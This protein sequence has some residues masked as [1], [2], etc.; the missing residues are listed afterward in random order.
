MRDG[1]SVTATTVPKTVWA[2]GFVSMLMDL[3][4]E[5]VHSLLPLF[6][7]ST[8]GVGALL[9]GLIEGI[10][11][12]TASITKLFSGA[13]SDR[14]GRRKGLVLFGY[15]LSALTKPVFALAPSV[16]WVVTA[17]FADRLGKGIRG[18]PRDALVADVTP[19]PLLGAAFG[20]RQSFDTVG[21]LAGPL[22]AM[23]LMGLTHNAFRLT[24]WAA[25]IPAAAAVLLIVFGVQEPE[26]HRASG[27]PG[28][29]FIQS[30][31]A[32]MG[33]AFWGA[34]AIGTLMT[35]ARFSEAFL[36][37]RAGSVGLAPALVPAVLVVMNLVYA[38]TAYP[39]GR[40]SDRLGRRGLLGAGFAVL[41][42]ADVV[43][44]LAG[45]V[46]TVLVGTGLWGLHMG[47]TQGLLTTL[48]AESAPHA[49]RGT[50]FG[51]FNLITG[52]TLLVASVLAGGLWSALGPSATFGAG[53]VLS[54][55]AL[56]GLALFTHRRPAATTA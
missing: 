8:L 46:W 26:A 47:M 18:A 4:S 5:I 7:V 45:S 56:L 22:L 29:H 19:R 23:A 3:S 21:A 42:A 53:A 35:L 13:L 37:L 48:V 6:L 9:L 54:T 20:L 38:S 44:A 2:L 30:D 27:K 16:G 28:V 32:S 34:V 41:V 1:K 12:A 25:A 39:V 24:F 31:I 52:V 43:L 11:E 50:A 55:L 51:V 49:V 40:L 15:G 10:A 17:R 14:T 36:I 33:G